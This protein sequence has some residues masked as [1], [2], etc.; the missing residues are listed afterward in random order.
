M[1]CPCCTATAW[2]PAWIPHL[3]AAGRV[4]TIKNWWWEKEVD[5]KDE[6]MLAAIRDC[7][8]AFGEYLEAQ[9]IRFGPDARHAMSSI[10]FPNQ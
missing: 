2:L 7:L 10:G 4:L 1:C 3:S 9:E 5:E 8:A 6:A